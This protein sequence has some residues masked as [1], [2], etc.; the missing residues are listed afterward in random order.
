MNVLVTGA[1]GHL[2]ANIVAHLN[3]AGIRPRVLMR[4]TSSTAA[5]GDLDYRPVL[6]DVTDYR[7]VSA[8]VEGVQVVYHVAAMV[9]F[10]RRRLD[11]MKRVNVGGTRNVIRACLEHGVDRLVHTS[12]VA[13]VAHAPSR[14]APVDERAEWNFDPRMSY[15]FTKHLSEL[16]V[17]EAVT[18][19]KL[20]AVVINPALIF[21]ERDVN[22][23]AGK[24][25][26]QIQRGW[27]LVTSPGTQAV[28]DADDVAA[29][30]LAAA[31]R[32]RDGARYIVSTTSMSYRSLF[33]QIAGRVGGR[34]PLLVAPAPLVRGAGWLAETIAAPLLR[35]E[36]A[37]TWEL[38]VQGTLH[39]CFDGRRAERELGIHYTPFHETLDKTRRW[40][41]ENGHM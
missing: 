25:L 18:T 8:A 6:G 13:A 5:I 35:R 17:L 31:E 21:G 22:L 26:I 11:Q 15:A 28:C 12:S 14:T 20:S 7:S 36:P 30:H 24:L 4:E 39:G 41:V 34:P 3:R 27:M 29:A 37:L 10:L 1:T 33:R 32:G 16:A 9:S 2:G 19:D 38:G 40:L 23:N